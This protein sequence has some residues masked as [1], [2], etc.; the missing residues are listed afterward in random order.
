MAPVTS[1][2]QVSHVTSLGLRACYIITYDWEWFEM[3]FVDVL[4]VFSD[5]WNVFMRFSVTIFLYLLRKFSLGS[6]WLQ[7]IIGSNGDL[8]SAMQQTINCS[9]VLVEYVSH[10][11]EK[12]KM[13]RDVKGKLFPEKSHTLFTDCPFCY[14]DPHKFFRWYM[15]NSYLHKKWNF[16]WNKNIT[17]KL[18]ATNDPIIWYFQY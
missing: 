9:N 13:I 7:D 16:G 4:N 2:D 11:A 8:S 12:P 15:H 3:Y 10:K 18:V 1:T 17:E 5:I 14:I 6:R